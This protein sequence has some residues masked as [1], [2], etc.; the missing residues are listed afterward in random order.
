MIFNIV[1][2][3]QSLDKITATLIGNRYQLVWLLFLFIIYEF[4]NVV[5]QKELRIE[6]IKF[7]FQNT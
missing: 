7:S 6:E 5:L 4:Q 3:N 2:V 1:T